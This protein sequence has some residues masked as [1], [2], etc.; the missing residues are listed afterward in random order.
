[1]QIFGRKNETK[2]KTKKRSPEG[3]RGKE[4]YDR[5]IWKHAE[6]TCSPSVFR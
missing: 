1:M 4:G 2:G 5:F 3:L 6:D